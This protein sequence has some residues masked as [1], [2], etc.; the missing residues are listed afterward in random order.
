MAD[1]LVLKSTVGPLAGGQWV[2]TEAGLRLGRE[3][4]NDVHIPDTNISRQHAR[5][6]LYKGVVWV[7]DA[8]SRNGVFV[9]GE[10]VADQKQV[11][12][13][14]KVAVGGHLF[15][16]VAGEAAPAP[17]TATAPITPS[18]PRVIPL[19]RWWPVFLVLGLGLGVLACAGFLHSS[20]T[21]TEQR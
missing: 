14:D 7:Q 12:A 17:I 16:I 19:Q 15:E 13:G 21:P 5:V 10:R 8:G 1:V 9:N 6:V 11:A 18:T 20:T 4:A 3:P 2:V